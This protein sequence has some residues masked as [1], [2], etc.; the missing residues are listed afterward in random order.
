MIRIV[1]VD[2]HPA[3]RHALRVRLALEADF[4]IV[5]EAPDGAQAL[6]VIAALRPDVALMDVAMPR[7]DGITATQRLRDIAPECAIVMMSVHDDPATRRQAAEAG[8][9]A[10]LGKHEAVG[11]ML[12]NT[13]RAVIDHGMS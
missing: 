12:A 9:A 10:F 5:G 11:E 13:L 3:V 4:Q 8:A 7:L 6:D 2:D 1:L